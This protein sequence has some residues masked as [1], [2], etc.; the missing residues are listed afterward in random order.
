LCHVIDICV[1]TK[2]AFVCK[3]C[4]HLL[5]VVFCCCDGMSSR[6][7][8]SVRFLMC[9]DDAPELIYLSL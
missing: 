8:K 1:S 6:S 5:F 7:L 2:V 4:R 3:E 9:V